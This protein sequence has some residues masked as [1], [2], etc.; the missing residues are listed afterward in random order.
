[1]KKSEG[2][3]LR[4]ED[5]SVWFGG[6]RALSGVTLD[7]PAGEVTGLIGP[8]GAGKTTLFDVVTGL[9]PPGEGRVLL[10]DADVT[11]TA[12][13]TRSRLGIARTFQ[14]LE[15]FGTLSVA[16]N[17]LVAAEM[18]RGWS[19]ER[20]DARAVARE[21][22]ERVG[23]SEVA[24]VRV[25]RLPT[26][27][28]RLVEL[29][30]ALA[31]RPRLL[32][33]D[34]PSSGLTEV[35][36]LGLA[37]LLREL[38]ASGLGVLLVEHD[39][40]LVMGAS[41]RVHVLELGRVIATGTPADVQADEG[42]RAAYLGD[43]RLSAPARAVRAP[44]PEAAPVL[45]LRDVRA[46]YGP[47]EVLHGVSLSVPAREVTALLGPNGAGKSTTMKVAAG[48]LVPTGGD[49]LLCG[50][51]VNG[52]GADVLARAGVRS[53]P[54]GRGVFPN[55]T[56]VEHLRMATHAGTPLADIEERAFGRFPRLRERRSQVVGTL[57]G[58]EQQMLAVA[59]VLS[60]DPA[61]LLLDEISM[62]LA[63]VLVDELY[64]AVRQA[65]DEGVSILIVEQFAAEVLALAD[66][67]AIMLNG[68]VQRVGSP[69]EIAD[70][71][72]SAYLAGAA[73]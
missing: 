71:L 45:E 3:L 21:A 5:V 34:E 31:T 70:E 8:N 24:D 48:R 51:R 50:R 73:G 41:D 12:P 62:G 35:E 28:T 29:A 11:A 40:S 38:A 10:E 7:A 30:R 63:P 15:V 49:L 61:L 53:V 16:E 44:A 9:Q 67:A 57:S 26:G 52:V 66:R 2:V 37:Q 23:L 60:T 1:V 33:L 46:A 27:R 32:L 42:V 43:R 25:D 19:R 56:V 65:A 20:L 64:E 22:V 47:I 69:A 58:G 6:V 4:V 36:T 54:E 39:M 17:V 59:R 55:L 14:R 68:R 18:R 13:H 72:A